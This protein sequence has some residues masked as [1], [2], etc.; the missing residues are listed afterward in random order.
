MPRPLLLVLLFAAPALAQSVG[1]EGLVVAPTRVVFEGRVR[2]A[3]LTLLNP[4]AETTTYRLSLMRMR[5]TDSG[6]I[7]EISGPPL[8]G[9]QFAEELIRFSPRQ[10]TLE[11]GTAQ[12]VRLQVRKPAE[13]ASGEY[14]SH[15]VFRALPPPGAPPAEL[16]GSK[17]EPQAFSVRLSVLYG[18]SIPVIVRHGEV[19]AAVRL[20][21]IELDRTSGRVRF[22]LS[23]SGNASVYGDVRAEVVSEAGQ[24]TEVGRMKGLAVYSPNAQRVVEL[25]LSGPVE[26]VPNRAT[27][28]VTYAR[29]EQDGGAT[30][31]VGELPL[32]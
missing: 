4:G 29:P 1:A 19:A 23:R 31:A 3:E 26:T 13:L 14:R 8:P 16:S 30:L 2:S 9:E 12:T 25:A 17:T 20:S 22:K 11:P 10:V 15:L 21:S 24:R 5:M 18:V 32:Q 6:A 7:Q 27:L 28:R